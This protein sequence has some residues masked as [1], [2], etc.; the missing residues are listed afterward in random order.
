MEEDEELIIRNT[1]AFGDFEAAF[2]ER[3]L[4]RATLIRGTRTDRDV[5]H[6]C[7]DAMHAMQG[8]PPVVDT[9]DAVTPLG[10]QVIKIT[11]ARYA[12]HPDYRPS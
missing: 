9:D 12:S 1:P 5:V 6:A 3:F 4:D 2:E 8:A 7:V 10:S 11:A